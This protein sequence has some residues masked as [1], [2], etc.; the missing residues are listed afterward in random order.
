MSRDRFLEL[1]NLYLDDEIQPDE[2]DELF[3]AIE[4]SSEYRILYNQYNRM[5][6]A[7]SMLEVVNAEPKRRRNFSQI[8]YAVGGMAAAFALIGLAAR[9][10]EPFFGSPER[11]FAINPVEKQ[12]S[13][14]EVLGPEQVQLA[15]FSTTLESSFDNYK[16]NEEVVPA[17]H[18]ATEF[19]WKNGLNL[20]F[21]PSKYSMNHEMSLVLDEKQKAELLSNALE[22]SFGDGFINSQYSRKA[23]IRV[24]VS[25]GEEIE[26]PK[27]TGFKVVLESN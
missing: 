6:A 2:I 16:Y 20:N 9:N 21:E 12:N 8:V 14:D 7:C 23:P 17:T 15:S 3:A 25:E 4:S 18:R 19:S 1:L 22:Q 13:P 26:L 5:T 27:T 10:L 11:P 24:S